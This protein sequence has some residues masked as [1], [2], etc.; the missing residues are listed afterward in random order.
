MI[1]VSADFLSNFGIFWYLTFRFF[2]ILAGNEF[3][4]HVMCDSA[5]I[6]FNDSKYNYYN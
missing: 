2:K 4:C 3:A 1:G 5:E 6:G